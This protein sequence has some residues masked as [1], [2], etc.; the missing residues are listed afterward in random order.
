MEWSNRGEREDLQSAVVSSYIFFARAF[1]ALREG[2]DDDDDDDDD[3]HI[4]A[5]C[6]DTKVNVSF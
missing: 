3:E 6:I 4:A 5:S 2:N 1:Y